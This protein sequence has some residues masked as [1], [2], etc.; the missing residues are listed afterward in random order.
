MTG[1][2]AEPGG[3]HKPQAPAQLVGDRGARGE[4][5]NTS[6]MDIE[7]VVG[8]HKAMKWTLGV[9]V[10]A[11]GGGFSTGGGRGVKRAPQNW[12]W[13]VGKRAQL[14]GPLLSDEVRR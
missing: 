1:M 6:I 5:Q 3:V 2:Y 14:T 7:L 10:G 9:A 8:G 4:A 12:G 13:G 11:G